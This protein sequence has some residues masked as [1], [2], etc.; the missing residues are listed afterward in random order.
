MHLELPTYNK[1][2]FY[3]FTGQHKNDRATLREAKKIIKWAYGVWCES[4]DRTQNNFAD[5]SIVDEV[6]VAYGLE[7][8][9]PDSPPW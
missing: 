6:R 8:G 9:L 4:Y 5:K 2:F 7:T 1:G 3:F